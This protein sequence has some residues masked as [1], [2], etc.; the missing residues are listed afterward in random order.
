[1][2]CNREVIHLCTSVGFVEE[3]N[4]ECLILPEDGELVFQATE[5]ATLG[6][7]GEG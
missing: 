1:M 7:A 5:A 4:A 2:K 3:S 6:T